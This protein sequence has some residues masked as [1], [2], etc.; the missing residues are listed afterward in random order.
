[1]F[2]GNFRGVRIRSVNRVCVYKY[3][4]NLGNCQI[5][6]QAAV[7]HLTFYYYVHNITSAHLKTCRHAGVQ[8]LFI[9]KVIG[10]F[11][12]SYALEHFKT[13]YQAHSS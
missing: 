2:S 7:P 1:M 13:F 5:Y 10:N 4:H 12:T 6:F 8:T 11:Q 3:T 9:R